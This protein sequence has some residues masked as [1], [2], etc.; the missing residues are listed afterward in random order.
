MA[1]LQAVTA[2]ARARHRGRRTLAIGSVAIAVLGVLVAGGSVARGAPAGMAAR[3]KPPAASAGELT[4]VTAVPH[5]PDVWAVGSNGTVD[6]ARFFV[7]QRHQGHWRAVKAPALAGRYG[8]LTTVAAGSAR[9]IW[10]GGAKQQKAGPQTM[11]AIW[12]LAGKKFVAQK[13]PALTDLSDSV[14]SISASSATNAWAVGGFY[15]GQTAAQVAFHWNGKKWS[16]V[17]VPSGYSQTLYDVSTS[18]PNNAW[19]LRSDY[20]LSQSTL[21]HWNGKAWTLSTAAPAGVTLTSVATSS[22]KLAYATGFSTTTGGGYRSVLMMFNGTKWSTVQL[23]K[24]L[25]HA[26]LLAVTMHGTSAWVIGV[27][28]TRPEILHSAG[29]GWKAEDSPG[30]DYRLFAI[31]AGSASRA[32]AVGYYDVPGS[33]KP[34]KTFFESCSA[35]SCTGEPS[36]L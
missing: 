32:S 3:A 35:R 4:A 26:E 16:A 21:V 31:S 1:E 15:P 28:A 14:R 19:A 7:G 8:S 29:G 12:R 11:P 5:S 33:G 27:T 2:P 34:S 20:A 10:L 6:N 13:L 18:G 9:T 36:K 23:A 25:G 30:K 24:S 22:A 17:T